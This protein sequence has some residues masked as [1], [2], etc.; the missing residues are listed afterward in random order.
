MWLKCIYSFQYVN[1]CVILVEMNTPARST[2]MSNSCIYSCAVYSI[3]VCVL[4]QSI[5]RHISLVNLSGGKNTST[6]V[7]CSINPIGTTISAKANCM[8]SN[9]GSQS[10]NRYS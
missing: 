1:K 9:I 5:Y 4:D 6:F 2:N 3:Q 8:A 7:E 10:E